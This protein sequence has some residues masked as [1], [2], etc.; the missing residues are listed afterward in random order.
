[1]RSRF[2]VVVLAAGLAIAAAACSDDGGEDAADT[3]EAGGATTTTAAPG[4][5]E[6]GCDAY[7]ALS[8]AVFSVPEDDTAGAFIESE[9]LPQLEVLVE[10]APE[11]LTE[12]AQTMLDIAG[13]SVEDP[14]RFD[15]PAAEAAFLA[16]G[17]AV[18]TGC[19]YEAVDVSAVDYGFEGLPE[20]VAG[21]TTSIALTNEGDEEHEMVLFRRAD[22]ETRPVDE[23]LALPE[24]EA[25]EALTFT[26]VAF[27]SPGDTGYVA[28]DLAAG[29]YVAV[30][31]IPVGG[32][33]D[34]PPH[35]TEGMVAEFEVA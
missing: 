33:E 17:D 28:T 15:D 23:L 13:E 1:M 29:D 31:F 24:A 6:A 12:Q 35:F 21:G 18:H 2:L 8:G 25:G 16:F 4:L 20:T 27:A 10:E 9:V 34:G 32:A 30:C 19:G 14:A 26:A 3:A 7:V 22:G 11:D 5:S